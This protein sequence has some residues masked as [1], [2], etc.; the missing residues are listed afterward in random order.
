MIELKVKSR[1][2]IIMDAGNQFMSNNIPSRK[3]M[4]MTSTGIVC[5]TGFGNDEQ[6]MIISKEI[7]DS[8]GN[9][10]SVTFCMDGRWM[11]REQQTYGNLKT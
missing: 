5:F 11:D 9:T 6:S 1:Q 4:K 2:E 8:Y 3:A 7:K 10:E